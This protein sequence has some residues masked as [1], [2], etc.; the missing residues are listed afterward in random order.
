MRCPYC[1]STESR[2]VDT[3]TVFEGDE[4]RRRR[5]CQVCGERFTTLERVRPNQPLVVKDSA[6]GLPARRELFDRDKLRRSIMTACAKRPIPEAAIDR[7]VAGIEAELR[8]ENA[9]E[10]SSRAIGEMV[11]RGLQGL[12]E[13]AYIR[14][15]I[16]FLRLEDLTA[17]QAEIERLLKVE[18]QQ[19]R[20]AM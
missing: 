14:Y 11:I 7:L 19:P 15:A 12:D 2:V 1:G 3:T 5:L 4:V 13:V 9:A 10:I 18:S 20:P 17:I 16:V 6:G 8:A